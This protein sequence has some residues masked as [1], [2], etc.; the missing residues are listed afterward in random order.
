MPKGFSYLTEEVDSVL[1]LFEEY[2]PIS[3]T[4]WERVAEVHLTRYPDLKQSVNSLKR[5]FKD[6]HNNKNPTGD[7][8]C[9]LAVCRAKRLRV[10]IICKLDASDLNSE[11]GGDSLEGGDAVPANLVGDCKED[12]LGVGLEEEEDNFSTAVVGEDTSTEVGVGEGG[13]DAPN[14][15]PSLQVSVSSSVGSVAVLSLPPCDRRA[16]TVVRA[17]S[18]TSGWQ[19]SSFASS[20]TGCRPATH[21]TPLSRP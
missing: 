17:N 21:M 19:L 14:A 6:L 7:P 5:K 4:A 16:A 11:E 18:I 12:E 9:P 10:D 2:L 3:S 8:L 13:D 20:A 1:D 15:R